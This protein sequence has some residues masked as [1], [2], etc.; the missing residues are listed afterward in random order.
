MNDEEIKKE[1]QK[2]WAKVGELEGKIEDKHKDDK[3]L[4]ISK[5]NPY[6]ENEIKIFCKN[7]DIREERLKYE[8]DFQ[9][10]FPRLINLP[11]ENV[12]TKLQFS[13]LILLAP[14]F[15]RIYKKDLS[16]SIIR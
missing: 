16:K 6:L 11:K 3:F 5:D 14:I 8:I 2:V 10:E 15:Y 1:F 7:S 4:E 12:R 13:V 9:K